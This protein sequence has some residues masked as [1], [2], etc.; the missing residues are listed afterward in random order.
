MNRV[1]GLGR[2]SKEKGTVGTRGGGRE[3]GRMHL[4]KGGLEAK[5]IWVRKRRNTLKSRR[6]QDF[7]IYHSKTARRKEKKSEEKGIVWR[8]EVG[9]G[10]RVHNIS[11]GRRGRGVRRQ[12]QAPGRNETASS[13]SGGEKR[14]IEGGRRV[15]RF[16]T[17]KLHCQEMKFFSKQEKSVVGGGGNGA[18]KEILPREP[19]RPEMTGR[20]LEQRLTHGI[21]GQN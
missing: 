6:S 21:L 13:P 5:T 3:K 7:P 1:C 10:T 19:G 15:E 2:F 8:K 14:R 9:F 12:F 11:R 4:Y 17:E 18:V 16:R 20:L